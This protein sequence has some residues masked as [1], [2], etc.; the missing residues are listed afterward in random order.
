MHVIFKVSH[1]LGS[2]WCI[3]D[4]MSFVNP[5]KQ[6]NLTVINGKKVYLISF[7]A[8]SFG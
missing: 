1:I 5:A 3:Q 6:Q 4:S 7:L 8:T 2:S